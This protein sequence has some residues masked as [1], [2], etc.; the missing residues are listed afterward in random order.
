MAESLW[1]WDEGVLCPDQE[2]KSY[3]FKEGKTVHSDFSTFPARNSVALPSILLCTLNSQMPR[4]LLRASLLPQPCCPSCLVRVPGPG[5]S[6]HW[7][8]SRGYFPSW[9]LFFAEPNRETFKA[10]HF[11]KTNTFA[12]CFYAFSSS[13][14]IHED[15]RPCF[16][17][18]IGWWL[19][20]PR[21]FHSRNGGS[22]P[23]SCEMQNQV[24]R[25]QIKYFTS[26]K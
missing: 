13:K 22:L 14:R 12:Y 9:P 24:S 23:H 11:Y 5:H 7:D 6:R 4:V 18:Y 16:L 17:G 1:L 2:P 10:P 19:I 25:D 15:N 26:T 8:M 20:Q 21:R 3:F